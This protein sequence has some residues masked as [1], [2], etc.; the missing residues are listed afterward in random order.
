MTVPAFSLPAVLPGAPPSPTGTGVAALSGNG[1]PFEGLL[2]GAIQAEQGG[3]S[4][5][6]AAPDDQTPVEVASRD[7]TS[8]AIDTGMLFLMFAPTA[9]PLAA[10][11]PPP[12]SDMVETGAPPATG[13]GGLTNA[14]VAPAPV[15]NDILGAVSLAT[16]AVVDTAA[17]EKIQAPVGNGR[18]D[19]L[20][21]LIAKAGEPNSPAARAIIPVAP[22]APAVAAPAVPMPATAE[23]VKAAAVA[24]PPL[25]ST[26]AASTEGD[27]RRAPGAARAE[28]RDSA[29]RADAAGVSPF[30]PK[31]DLLAT[32]VAASTSPAT[33]EADAG[34]DPAPDPA[35][36]DTTEAPETRQPS[37]IAEIRAQTTQAT[38]A[39]ID[40]AAV[41]GSPETVAKLA[42]DIVRKLDGQSTRFDLQLDPHGMGKVDVAIEIDRAGKL[43][44]A[45]S[46]DSAQSASDLR[47]RAG[48]LR[49]ALEQA[50][51]DIAEGGLSF[52]LSDQSAGFGG[53]E[54][55]QQERA[56]N[57]RA[58]QRAQSGAEDADLSLA[59]TPSTS[60]RWTR[61]G[62]DIRI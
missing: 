22:V 38:T 21:G 9:A 30:A 53:R 52:D 2:A 7:E 56:W 20:A 31:S 59:A 10:S 26:K 29:S 5:A 61:S 11:T 50:G 14:A 47:G 44:A 54:A 28:R 49:L 45:L 4:A 35:A 3:W 43:T 39:A 40:A 18:L 55:G 34:S 8:P 33:G 58:F 41:R 32:T 25:G 16:T 27:S 15:A 51:F 24:L 1:G 19:D 13:Q 48:E 60:S 62:V 46:F 17:S 57:G 12:P 42:A 6:G 23:E 36:L 37:L